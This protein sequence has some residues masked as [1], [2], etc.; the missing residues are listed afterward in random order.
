MDRVSAILARL[1]PLIALAA[2]VAVSNAAIATPYTV[3]APLSATISGNTGVL[4]GLVD[5]SP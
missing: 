4:T 1:T 3:S 5:L 2:F